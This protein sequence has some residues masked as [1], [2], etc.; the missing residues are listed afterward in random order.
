M[1][2]I[3]FKIAAFISLFAMVVF[4]S[5]GDTGAM[6]MGN[7]VLMAVVCAGSFGF[8]ARLSGL[9]RIDYERV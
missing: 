7:A 5:K 9:W 2:N 4:L 3:L 1:K 6:S 8:F